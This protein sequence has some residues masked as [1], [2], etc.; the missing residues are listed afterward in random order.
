MPVGGLSSSVREEKPELPE[1]PEQVELPRTFPDEGP[2]GSYEIVVVGESSAAGVP[3]D[4]WLSIGNIVVWQ[5]KKIVPGRRFSFTIL[6]K[7]GDT[8]ERQH[9]RLAGLKKPGRACDLRGSQRI[10]GA[11]SLAAQV[12]HYA[13]GREPDLRE[14]LVQ[15][16]ESRSPLCGWIREEINKCRVSLPPSPGS[17]RRLVDEPVYTPEELQ[18]LLSDFERRLDAMVSFAERVRALP[19]LI[20]PPSNE[21]D[22]E[23]NRSYLPPE[24]TY[25]Q[26]EALRE[27]LAVRKHEEGDLQGSLMAYQSLL[28]RYPGFAELH[29]R[30]ARIQARLGRWEEAYRQSVLAREQD[31]FPERSLTAIQEIYRKVAV[32]HRCTLIDAQE[33]FHKIGY[34]G[35]LDDHLFHDAVHPSLRGH[36]ALAQAVLQAI[37]N[38][39]PVGW[40]ESVGPPVIDP[41]EVARHFHLNSW[42]WENI[43][44]FGIM[45]YDLTSGLHYDP[46]ERTAKRS[47]FGRA[48]KRLKRGE[49]PEALGLANVGVAEPVPLVPTAV[50][51]PLPAHPGQGSRGPIDPVRPG[52]KPRY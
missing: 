18:V 27:F 47:S 48:L 24:T 49:R 39:R 45:F 36:L 5:L 17:Y 29:F 51:I 11:V 15:W 20:V 52:H 9:A 16:V 2:D 30:M 22:Y 28:E 6:A 41:D 12:Y 21:F 46:T 13:D 1:P 42:A 40:P 14:L 3:Y 10:H 34:H 44:N 31:G 32:R 38:H 25:S 19:I 8:L 7:A 35:L 23:P 26:R 43:C 50:F 33:Y 37:R 4:W